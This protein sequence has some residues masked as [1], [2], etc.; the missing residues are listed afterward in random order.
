MI[1]RLPGTLDAM[2]LLRTALTRRTTTALVSGALLLGGTAACSQEDQE[3]V[4]DTG[5]QVEQEVEEGTDDD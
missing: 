4:E 3:Q 5:D 2:S 1:G